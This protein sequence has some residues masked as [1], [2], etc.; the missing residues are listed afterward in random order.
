LIRR[1]EALDFLVRSRNIVI[2]V[3]GACAAILAGCAA[4]GWFVYSLFTGGLLGYQPPPTP[5]E[6]KEARIVIGKDFLNRSDFFRSPFLETIKGLGRIN[7]VAVGE[8][9]PHP[10]LDVVVAGSNGALVLDRSGAQEG[11]TIFELQ[12]SNQKIGPFNTPKV[13][14]SIGDIQIVDLEGDGICEYLARGSLDGGAVFDHQGKLLWT[15]GKYTE[16]RLFIRDLTVGDLDGDGIAEFVVNWNGIEVFDKSG[17]R[18]WQVAEEY[19]AP[20]I[21]VVDTDGDGKNEIISVEATLTIRDATGRVIKDVKIPA[22]YLGHFSLCRMPGKKYP[23]ILGV[24]DGTL[25]LFDFEGHTVAQFKAPLSKFDDTVQRM[26]DGEEV[27]GT[28]VYK[29]KAMWI[30]LVKDRPEYLAVITEFVAIDRSVFDIFTRSGELVYQ[31]VVPEECLSLAILPPSDPS[32]LPELLVGGRQTVW[33]Y[34]VT[35]R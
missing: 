17:K 3:V 28:S 13:D 21:E 19:G 9:D 6:L 22:S 7:D 27:R 34:R 33:R 26:P 14:F 11:R 12:V 8:F 4:L 23:A 16:G 15:Y 1:I 32:G 18:R 35:G 10:G 30:K 5:A 31:E 24:Q 25:W 29:S 20:Q 2:V